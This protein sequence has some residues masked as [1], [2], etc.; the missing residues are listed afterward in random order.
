MVRAENLDFLL[1]SNGSYDFSAD[2]ELL[3]TIDGVML[4]VKAW[5]V[6]EHV[7]LTGESNDIVLK[8]LRFLAETG[9]LT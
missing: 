9:K 6:D 1:D 5:N 7:R 8:N 4:D 3:D 2:T